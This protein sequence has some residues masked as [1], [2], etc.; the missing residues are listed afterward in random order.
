MLLLEVSTISTRCLW[1][2]SVLTRHQSPSHIWLFETPM[3]CRPPGSSVHEIVQARILG[4]IAISYSRGSSGLRNQTHVS[5]S[6][7]FGRQIPYHYTPGK[8]VLLKFNCLLPWIIFFWTLLSAHS[9]IWH[10]AG[11]HSVCSMNEQSWLAPA[12]ST[13]THVRW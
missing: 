7:C 8:L 9:G 6:S 13:H 5:I 4:W 12:R 11:S 2:F 1:S 10:R 3:D